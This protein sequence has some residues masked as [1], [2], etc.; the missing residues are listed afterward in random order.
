MAIGGIVGGA[1]FGSVMN[2]ITLIAVQRNNYYTIYI[3]VVFSAIHAVLNIILSLTYKTLLVLVILQIT[4][5]LVAFLHGR[6]IKDNW[7]SNEYQLEAV[8]NQNTNPRYENAYTL[9]E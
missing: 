2:I 8:M 6:K 4:L 3:Y 1:L 9:E 5:T 7:E